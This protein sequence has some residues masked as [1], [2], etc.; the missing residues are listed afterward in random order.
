ME[1]SLIW[2]QTLEVVLSWSCIDLTKVCARC[3][4][5]CSSHFSTPAERS[6]WLPLMAVFLSGQVMS[7]QRIPASVTPTLLMSP[8]VFSQPTPHKG[9]E[10]GRLAAASA[11]PAASS[12]SLL[13]PLPAPEP[14]VAS[15]TCITKLQLQETLLH[16]IQVQHSEFC[17]SAPNPAVLSVPASWCCCVPI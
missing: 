12:G 15:S 9:A 17:C 2:K 5:P 4:S 13:L 11:E 3:Q 7:P 10:S 8:M 14:A 16:L 6:R 1:A